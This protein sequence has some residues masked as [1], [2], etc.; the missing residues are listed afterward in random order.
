MTETSSGDS[1][2]LRLAEWIADLSLDDI[3]ITA[4]RAAKACILDS[5]GCIVAG[6]QTT[7][8]RT[9]LDLLVRYDGGT[10]CT[11]IGTKERL[12]VLKASYVMAQGANVLDF[13]DSFRGG[14]ASHPGATVISP[15]L[16]LAEQAGLSGLEF[17]RAVVAGYEVSLRIGRA[18]QPSPERER[19]VFGYAT[20]QSFGALA[21]AACLFRLPPERIVDAMGIGALH[22]TLPGGRKGG[23]G[24]A[25]PFPWLKNNYGAASEAGIWAAMLAQE[26]YVGHRRILEGP[27]G[28]WIMAGSDHYRPE[29]T[30]QGLGENWLI[31]KVG[32]KPYACCRWTHTMLDALAA[33]ADRLTQERV[34]AITLEGFRELVDMGQLWPSSIM[35]AQFNPRYL[36]ALEISGKSPQRGLSEGDLFDPAIRALAE[37]VQLRHNPAADAGFYQA[38]TLPVR[39]TIHLKD[40]TS[41]VV[42]REN[43]SGGAKTGG[44][45]QDALEEKFIQLAA[46]V[47]G[48][49]QAARIV[50]AVNEIET[51]SPADLALLTVPD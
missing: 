35:D 16:A 27:T 19:Q 17:L 49:A 51:H 2:T 28:F 10:N 5:L 8:C 30:T 47:L 14:A 42:S 11:I 39:L 34:A 13:D 9:M 48:P 24:D 15:A 37:K 18:I 33:S 1:E 31:E 46:P 50:A 23:M 25:A 32:F 7:P 44:F 21:V 4:L 29:L 43:P 40:G 20:W 38:G 3:P 22:A 26:G 6:M 41:F 45:P 12:S 36:A